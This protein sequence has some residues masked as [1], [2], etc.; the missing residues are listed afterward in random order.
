[1]CTLERYN[2]PDWAAEA[3]AAMKRMEEEDN[4]P[5]T[6]AQAKPENSEVE[7]GSNNDPGNSPE[8]IN[9]S[10]LLPVQVRNTT[11]HSRESGTPPTTASTTAATSHSAPSQ[12]STQL[13]NLTPAQQS[14]STT[15]PQVTAQSPNHTSNRVNH[16]AQTSICHFDVQGNCRHGPLEKNCD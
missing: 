8:D 2:D 13:Q 4:T 15:P 12:Y 10:Q 6:P 16:T 5:F 9:L 3:N 11:E 1:M 14:P 7:T